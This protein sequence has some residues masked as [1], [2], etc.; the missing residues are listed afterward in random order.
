MKTDEQPQRPHA[1]GITE[2]AAD[3][4]MGLFFFAIGVVMIVDNYKL[5]AGWAREGPESGYFP[6]RIGVII[7]I[8]AAIVV[9]RRAFAKPRDEEMFVTMDRLKPVLLLLAPTILY[10]LAIQFI[11]IYV[12]SAVFIGAFMRFMGRYS[13]LKIVLVSV[14]FAVVLFW[15]FEVQ[16]TVPLPKGPLEALLGY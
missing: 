2:R 16:F 12:A 1:S 6:M 4:G 14:G 15:L 8:A 9:A 11:G 10:V 7:C 13:W 5:G 3:I